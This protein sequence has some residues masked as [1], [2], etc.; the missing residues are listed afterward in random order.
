MFLLRVIMKN[1][2]NIPVLLFLL[3]SQI[4][5]AQ[6]SI[7]IPVSSKNIDSS[8]PKYSSINPG[9]T[10]LVEAGIRESLLFANIQGTQENPIVIINSGGRV[11]FETDRS[12]GIDLRNCSHIK[13][14]GTGDV[15]ERYGFL[16]S[17]LPNENSV[18][19]GVGYKS[20]NFEIEN[21][22]ISHVS[23]AGILAKTNPTCE[24]ISSGRGMFVQR[25]SFIHDLYIHDVSGEGIYLGSSKFRDSYNLSD[26]DTIVFSHTLEGVRVYNNIIENSG[27]DGIQVSSAVNDCLIYNNIIS[28]DS[29]LEKNF[30]M[31]GIII[32]GG[33][34]CDCYNNIIKDGKGTGILYFG[35]GGGKIYNNL[36]INSGLTHFPED[37]S[38][39][40]HGIYI[41]DKSNGFADNLYLFNNTIISPKTNGIALAEDVIH[42]NYI[43]NNI[44]INPGAFGNDN[45]SVEEASINLLSSDI[46]IEESH[47][48]MAIQA[49]QAGFVDP[50]NNDFHLKQGSQ[51]IDAGIDLQVNGISFDLEYNERPK[52]KNFDIGA[53]ESD[54]YST[55]T[56]SSIIELFRC[57]PNPG[58][59]IITLNYVL[60]GAK[61]INLYL[62]DN[63]GRIV[64]NLVNDEI[65]D[66]EQ[67]ITI[68]VSDFSERVIFCVL[69]ANGDRVI[70]K[71]IVMNKPY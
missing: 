19:I 32:G 26:C 7:I 35:F 64:K 30:Q 12:Y 65:Q 57:F 37:P 45:V 39:K 71:L 29:R 67:N 61:R 16:I 48:Y 40:Q 54:W 34:Y 15:N 38:K 4:I 2:K 43:K 24:D 5:Y 68:D 23:F 17:D 60:T 50:D 18:G 31:S 70:R 14:T 47:N 51:L 42:L 11:I 49:D 1:W 55:V 56:D 44:I 36:I 8:T 22:E 6:N 63:L 33:S 53:Y 62:C 52:G 69:E 10:L 20:T 46:N 58:A 9:D 3:L 13:L 25:N 66:G 27:M 59:E 41:D 28:N 21:I